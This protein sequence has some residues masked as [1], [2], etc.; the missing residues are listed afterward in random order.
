MNTINERERNLQR[1]RP[2]ITLV[3]NCASPRP[4][5]TSLILFAKSIH[6]A[7][8]LFRPTRARLSE[9]R[10]NISDDNFLSLLCCEEG[11]R[12]AHALHACLRSSFKP[13]QS[14]ATISGL[15]VLR[16]AVVCKFQTILASWGPTFAKVC[17]HASDPPILP[18]ICSP[19]NGKRPPSIVRNRFAIAYSRPNGL[20]R[21]R[22]WF[23]ID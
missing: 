16:E 11:R 5:M 17:K 23:R 21:R 7:T 2:P 4:T 10:R 13:K 19:A 18:I 14:I 1:R 22:L 9:R 3:V 6:L 15:N 8:T 20:T 12:S